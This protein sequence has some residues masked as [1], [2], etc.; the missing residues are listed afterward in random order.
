MGT[1]VTIVTA[2]RIVRVVTGS[3]SQTN[4]IGTNV[5]V[6]TAIR[7]TDTGAARAGVRMGTGVA[8][9]TCDHI[10][11]IGALALPVIVGGS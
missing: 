6:A 2:D 9:I 7:G 3:I 10:V 8:I 4:I 11:W 1:V 5:G